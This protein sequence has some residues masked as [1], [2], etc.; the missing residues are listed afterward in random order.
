MGRWAESGGWRLE[1]GGRGYGWRAWVIFVAFILGL[2][3]STSAQTRGR[4]QPPRPPRPRNTAPPVPGPERVRVVVNGGVQLA[5]G[6]FG[7]DFSLT[8]NVEATPITTDLS[9]TPGGYIDAGARV[10]VTRT[11][12]IG[13]VAFLGASRADGTVEAQ[14]PHPFYFNRPRAISGDLA[15]L[16]HTEKGVH[17]ELAYPV[18]V[19]KGR[20]FTVFGGPS[21]ISAR[22][23]LVTDVTYTD[24]YPYDSAAY[25]TATTAKVSAAAFGVNAGADVTWRLS[26]SV[27]AGVL[28]RYTWAPLS[29]TAG[30]GNVVDLHA[31]G[32][33]V[34]GG[35]RILMQKRLPRPARPTT[36]ARPRR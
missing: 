23:A 22:Q 11:L 27:R 1:V 36:P 14:I 8:K 3:S 7:Q 21:Y 34:A 29:L 16:G 28:L 15:Q 26:R 25:S 2:A 19:A 13:A 4:Q 32:L 30:S 6:S 18:S 20:E 9:L 12:S 5:P 33:Q 24:S 17:L 35:L 10:R 31:G